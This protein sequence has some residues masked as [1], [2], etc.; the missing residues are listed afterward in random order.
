MKTTKVMLSVLLPL[1]FFLQG[2]VLLAIGTGAAA[3][4]GAVA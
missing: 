4:A 2:C 1:S 3:G